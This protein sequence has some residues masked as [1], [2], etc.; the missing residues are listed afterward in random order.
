MLVI[1]HLTFRKPAHIKKFNVHNTAVCICNVNICNNSGPLA[2]HKHNFN[3]GA[4]VVRV[5]CCDGSRSD[6]CF[7]NRLNGLHSLVPARFLSIL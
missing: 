3:I 6:F 4:K 2:A 7:Y 1:L 5:F